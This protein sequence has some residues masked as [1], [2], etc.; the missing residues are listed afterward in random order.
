M[1]GYNM[2]QDY[3]IDDN[4]QFNWVTLPNPLSS[5]TK[6]SLAEALIN[7]KKEEGKDNQVRIA[8]KIGATLKTDGLD[9]PEQFLEKYKT[10]LDRTGLDIFSFFINF[11]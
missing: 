7:K 2:N 4:D 10:V 5:Y 1:G 3:F 9:T 6:E 8:G 11:R